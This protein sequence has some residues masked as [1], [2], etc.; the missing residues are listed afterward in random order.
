MPEKTWCVVRGTSIAALGSLPT[1]VTAQGRARRN[2][3]IQ[4]L[5][6]QGKVRRGSR[7]CPGSTVRIAE[8][9]S[10]VRCLRRAGSKRAEQP[11]TRAEHR[12]AQ[13]VSDVHRPVPRNGWACVALNSDLA[14]DMQLLRQLLVPLTPNSS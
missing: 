8:R 7:D 13:N 1:K 10:S 2:A 11:H 9:D 5:A 12:P 6:G 3:A 4:C 14:F